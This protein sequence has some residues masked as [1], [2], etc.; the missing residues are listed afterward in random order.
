MREESS[1]NGNTDIGF[2]AQELDT[3]F[4]TSNDY[5]RIVSKEDPEK[6][7]VAQG[8]LIPILVNAVKELSA[9]NTA[10]KNLIKNSSSFAALKSSL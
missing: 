2:I 6:L 10:L 8:Q 7:A 1:N 5:V 4:G 3:A 9:E